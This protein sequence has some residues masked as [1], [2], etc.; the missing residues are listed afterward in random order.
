[1]PPRTRMLLLA[2]SLLVITSAT[3]AP[4]AVR[5]QTYSISFSVTGLPVGV[6]SQYYVDGVLNGTIAT[7]ETKTFEFAPGSAHTIGVDLNVSGSNG[8]RYQCRDN[9]WQ[10]VDGG[11]HMFT[12][13]TQYYL[14]VISLYGSP[15]GTDWYDDGAIAQA[16][17][18][19]NMTVGPE[20]TRYIF[21]KWEQD[22]S[23]QGTV[24]DPIIMNRPK[25]AAA[26]W[27]TQYNMRISYDP[28]GVFP[29]TSLWF[30]AGSVAEF[31]APE[32]T[33]GT[34]ARQ[35]FVQWVGDFSGTSARGSLKMDAPKSVTA[36]YKAQYRLS[37]SF[38]PSEIAQ[39]LTMPNS[40]WYDA[41][42]I[43]TLGPVPQIITI[44]DSPAQRFVWFS[45]NVDDMIQQG[46]SVQ[47]VMDR[48]HNVR[49]VYQTQYYLLVTSTLGETT[50][51]GWYA[52]G[53]KA[54][55]GVTYSGPELLVKHTLASWRLNSSGVVRTLPP[56][57]TEVVVD[58]PYVVEA[59]WSTDYTPLW[60]FVFALASAVV[61]VG[62]VIVIVSKRPGSFRALGLS[63]R[64]RL[65]RRKTGVPDIT[66]GPS[67]PCARCGAQIPGSAE[68]CQSCGAIQVRGQA[69]ISSDFERI[70][71]RVYDYIAKRHGEISLIQA[72]K[73]LGLSADEVRLSTERLK[74]KGRLA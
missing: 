16:R 1:M 22:A 53:Q 65:G 37:L 68:Y 20:G 14:E 46:T 15:S 56:T 71:N 8:T 2:V 5:A 25:K 41:G 31:A 33:N 12:Y 55:F 19:T 43:A 39:I 47:V 51:T 61:V 17:L 64:S 21:S 59:Q 63:L 26:A 4:M 72:S 35:V 34:D 49:L 60:I 3:F 58:R 48:S 70:D 62:S 6:K 74:R 7:G 45:W 42:Q 13:K 27:K 23:G 57:E 9:L 73:D 44:P 50:G 36:K 54:R 66:R 29:P 11:V 38:D 40:T 28:V 30:D 10:F 24:S 67:I 69:P 52:N 32:G 18:A